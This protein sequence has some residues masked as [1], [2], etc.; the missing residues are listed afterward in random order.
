MP[1]I[2]AARRV[3]H[4]SPGMWRSRQFSAQLNT[5][6]S[7]IAVG[8]RPGQIVRLGDVN[9]LSLFGTVHMTYSSSGTSCGSG[10]YSA[11][12]LATTGVPSGRGMVNGA[13]ISVGK[14]ISLGGG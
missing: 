1:K 7:P 11:I 5:S 3:E 4:A 2:R 12:H 9:E 13:E 14:K 8:Y 6:I 10:R